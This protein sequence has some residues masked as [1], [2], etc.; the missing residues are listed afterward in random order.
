MLF[1]VEFI[2]AWIPSGGSAPCCE[3]VSVRE[4]RSR[5]FPAGFLD[6]PFCGWGHYC[7]MMIQPVSTGLHQPLMLKAI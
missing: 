6:Q 3:V 4:P 2:F 7:E 1:S 5:G